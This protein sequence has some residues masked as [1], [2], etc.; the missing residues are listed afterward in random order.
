V[1][2]AVAVAARSPGDGL[3]Y[4]IDAA[5]AVFSLH[6]KGTR[7]AVVCGGA[8]PCVSYGRIVYRYRFRSRSR[9]NPR[10][11]AQLRGRHHQRLVGEIAFTPRGSY[12]AHEQLGD[13]TLCD[14]TEGPQ[15]SG[16][17]LLDLYGRNG[18]T[19][20]VPSLQPALD[21]LY[22]C[23]QRLASDI[24]GVE[25]PNV[26]VAT[27]RLRGRKEIRLHI[28]RS[29]PPLHW[30]DEAVAFDGALKVDMRV[31]MRR[32]PCARH[33]DPR[34]CPL[35]AFPEPPSYFYP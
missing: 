25:M 10:G 32:I 27:K 5:D 20:V 13:R 21:A 18:R 9:W 34:T 23:D 8:E 29:T 30:V 3:Y 22:G 35:T 6:Y 14:V 1:C 2:P 17:Q 7:P 11:D 19:R 33:V 26:I 16:V 12:S 31:S 4:K 15:E 28:H 24:Q